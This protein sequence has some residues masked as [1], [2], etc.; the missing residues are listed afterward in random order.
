MSV[1]VKRDGSRFDKLEK[2]RVV[3]SPKGRFLSEHNEKHN[4]KAPQINTMGMAI[5]TSIFNN[6]RSEVSSSTRKGVNPFA[7]L[8][9]G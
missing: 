9:S 3:L 8:C 7:S 6:L 5:I 4:T 1:I 2:I